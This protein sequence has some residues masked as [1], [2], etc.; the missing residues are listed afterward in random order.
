[1]LE[2]PL[3]IVSYVNFL[4]IFGVLPVNLEVYIYEEFIFP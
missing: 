2:F 3:R 4:E 1:M